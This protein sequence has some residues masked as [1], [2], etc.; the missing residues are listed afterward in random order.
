MRV[1]VDT[2]VLVSGLLTPGGTPG[3]NINMI[4]EGDLRVCHDPRIF[5]EYGAVLGR[6]E[7]NI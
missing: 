7:F 5:E 6:P 2:N 3:S 4:A 1:V